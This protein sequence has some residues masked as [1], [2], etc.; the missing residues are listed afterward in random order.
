MS[1]SVGSSLPLGKSFR[2]GVLR[3]LRID[4]L[5]GMLGWMH[6]PE[7][8]GKFQ[9]DFM[10]MGERDA[11]EFI[12]TSWEDRSSIHLAIASPE[13]DEY[14]GTVSLKNADYVDLCAEYA[15]ATASRA[16]GTGVALK[17]TEE[18]LHLAFNSLGLNRIYLNVRA[19][20]KRALA[21]YDKV[22]F[23]REGLA[24]QAIKDNRGKFVDLIWLSMLASEF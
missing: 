12:R 14:L 22:G 4:D 2:Q 20:N 11:S 7:V 3:S 16:H 10:S 1:D 6:D 18:I 13:N 9:N 23:V 15:I 21:F 24:R 17:A 8:A 19:D 5:P